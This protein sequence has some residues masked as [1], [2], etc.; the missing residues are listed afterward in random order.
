[1]AFN[2][3]SNAYTFGFATLMV[4]VVAAVLSFVA[5]NLK[6]MQDENV[7]KEKMQNILSS[8]QINVD[9]EEAANIY[10]D[11]VLEELVVSGGQIVNDV[12]AFTIDMVK[13]V[14]LE[15]NER[16]A[17]LYVAE[18]DGETFYIIPLQGT[19]LWGPIWGYI[20]LEEDLNTIYG[21]VFDHKAETPG[22]GAEIKYPI[23]TEQFVGKKILADDGSLLGIDVRKGDSSTDYQV[24]GISGGT[25]TSDG[26]EVMILDC[27][28]AYFPFL[29]EYA[30]TT[31][32]AQLIN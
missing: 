23:F 1:M 4:L 9:R 19:G 25:I 17:P 18:K 29:K 20:S 21:A 13:Q 2:V 5:T 8:I 32:S 15:N 22:L 24:D 10:D 27:L 11:Y 6:P 7:E 3:N 31:A 30:G 12:D 14:R 16:N 26:V 28:E